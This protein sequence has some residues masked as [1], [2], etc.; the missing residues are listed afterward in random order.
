MVEAH[1]GQLYY[2]SLFKIKAFTILLPT[3]SGAILGGYTIIELEI[4]VSQ[5]LTKL[6]GGCTAG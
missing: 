5:N 6:G 3:I 1:A 4:G 2:N